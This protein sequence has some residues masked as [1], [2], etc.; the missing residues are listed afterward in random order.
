MASSS[1][2]KFLFGSE[3][4]VAY[5][6]FGSSI[7]LGV[8]LG[9]AVP[10]DSSLPSPAWRTASNLVG[11]TYFSAWSISFYPQVRCRPTY[12]PGKGVL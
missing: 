8:I 4:R 6:L 12:K 3:T 9:L 10:G 1:I 11:W 5:T 7:L 2:T